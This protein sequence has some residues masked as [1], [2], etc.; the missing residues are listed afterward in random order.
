VPFLGKGCSVLAEKH[1]L[2]W[3]ICQYTPEA[4]AEALVV[5]ASSEA[6]SEHYHIDRCQSLLLTANMRMSD[7]RMA[8]ELSVVQVCCVV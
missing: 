7:S 5:K 3:T 6:S 1:R 4:Q 8:E 2:A